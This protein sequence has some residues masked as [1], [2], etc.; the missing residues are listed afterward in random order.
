M[1]KT[2]SLG[3][4]EAVLRHVAHRV[5]RVRDDDEDRVRGVLDRLLGDRGDDRLV[6]RHEVVAA[7]ARRARPAGRDDDDVGVGRVVVGVRAGDCGLV[8]EHRA[9]LVHVERL[10]LRQALDDVDEDDVRVVAARD[11]LRGG[12]ADVPRSDDGDLRSQTVD[13]HLSR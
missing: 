12:R 7:H 4:P 8:A 9:G 6:R 5:E 10:A 11:L 1:P 13:S 2:R 3:K